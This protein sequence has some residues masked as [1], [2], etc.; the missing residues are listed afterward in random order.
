MN[1]LSGILSE[2]LDKLLRYRAVGPL[3]LEI[4]LEGLEWSLLIWIVSALQVTVLHL[5][6]VIFCLSPSLITEEIRMCHSVQ[7]VEIVWVIGVV[8]R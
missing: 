8:L 4:D 1:S 2:S 6:L 5:Y 7:H 3:S